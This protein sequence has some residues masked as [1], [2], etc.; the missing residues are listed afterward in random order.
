[1]KI[2][3][4][5]HKELYT[6]ISTPAVYI[7]SAIF[8]II[9]GVFFVMYLS[10]TNYSDTSIRGFM[11]VAPFLI[12][13]Y[14]SVLSMR[15]IAEEKKLGTWE[16]LLTSPISDFEI[17]VSKYL[18]GVSVLCG[19]FVLTS[20]FP[21]LLIFFGD[22]DMGSIVTSYAGLILLGGAAMSIGIFA[23]SVTSNQIVAVVLAIG[24]M[25]GLWF[26]ESAGAV[27]GG[28]FGSVFSSLSL[29]FYFMDF[30]RGVIDTRSIVYFISVSLVFLYLSIRSIEISRWR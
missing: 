27:I 22:P 10:G 30:G 20:Y 21:F 17:I 25:S 5:V 26:I 2:G 8:M 14:A 23:S 6:Y 13:V 4:M 16:M 1:M 18:A 11:D 28:P 24:I 12:I 3:I 15:M 7:I 19:L 9:S 29:S